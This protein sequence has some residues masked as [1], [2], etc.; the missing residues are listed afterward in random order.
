[1]T[2][3]LALLVGQARHIGMHLLRRV[4]DL[5]LS[6]Q[7]DEEYYRDADGVDLFS[8]ARQRRTSAGERSVS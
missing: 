8:G 3:A 5:A 4:D 2:L 7:Q 1:M 6:E